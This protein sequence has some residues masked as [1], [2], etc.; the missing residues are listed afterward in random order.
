M[1]L[2]VHA[3]TRVLMGMRGS[4]DGTATGSG[5]L[6]RPIRHR[7]RAGFPFVLVG[8]VSGPWFSDE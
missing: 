6:K 3:L 4:V 8:L 7:P 2:S 1:S 5:E